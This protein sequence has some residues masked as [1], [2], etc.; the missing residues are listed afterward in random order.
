MFNNPKIFTAISTRTLLFG[1]ILIGIV[2]AT[3][4][5]AAVLWFDSKASQIRSAGRVAVIDTMAQSIA[6]AVQDD[7]IAK[8]YASIES[9]LKQISGDKRVISVLILD[10]DR[11]VLSQV[12]RN[13]NSESLVSVYGEYT[14]T[15]PIESKKIHVDGNLASEW[16]R[17]DLGMPVGWLY[18]EIG[19]VEVDQALI[20]FRREF[21]FWLLAG[22]LGLLILLGSVIAR[23]YSLLKYEDSVNSEQKKSL[24]QIA[25]YDDLTGLPN[26]HLLMDRLIQA[27]AYSNRYHRKLAIC[28]M[29][30]DGFKNVNDHYGHAAGDLVLKE[31]ANRLRQCVR[32]LDTVSRIG[33][34]EFVALLTNI[35]SD[36][37][38]SQVVERILNEVN[39]PIKLLEDIFV[40]VSLSIGVS[41]YPEAGESIDNVLQYADKAMYQAKK[42][43]KNRWI[44]SGST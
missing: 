12:I 16:L 9:H 37:T 42:S 24:T 4:S 28:F 14:R 34:D 18:L 29:D 7:L 40:T 36:S 22:V 11:K 26:R 30:I 6:V 39:K 33:G 19:E 13:K 17:I 43:G 32:A 8:N 23:T 31:V 35:D 1:S 20:H 25:N 5:I 38:Y 2:I 3:L 21:S 10:S 44:L 15:T 27:I 41:L